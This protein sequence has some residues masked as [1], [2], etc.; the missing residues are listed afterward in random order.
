MPLY[1]GS[2]CPICGK[3][4]ADTDD[5]VV[6]PIC[7][8]PHHRECYR[9][10]GHCGNDDYHKDNRQWELPEELRQA[11]EP[12]QDA[13]TSECLNC[14]ARNPA[15]GCFCQ[16]CGCRLG[17]ERQGAV[18]PG[19]QGGGL[20]EDFMRHANLDYNQV[21]DQG[22]T[23]KDACDYV[24]QNS[25]PF[26]LKFRAI[27]ARGGMTFN[28]CAFFFGFFYCF[29]RKMYK[30]GAVLLAIFLILLIPSGYYATIAIQ[31][32]IN[33]GAALTLPIDFVVEGEGFKGLMMVSMI[34]R[35]VNMATMLFS[36]FFFNKLYY[37]SMLQKVKAVRDNPRISPGTQEY[38][39][40]VVAQGGVNRG[41]VLVLVALMVVV[42]MFT[43]FVASL[44]VVL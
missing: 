19:G 32:I 6:C 7:G 34:T 9:V 40:A 20:F 21:L 29:Y 15:G 44:F 28:W 4:F 30:L 24:G 1:T 18:P 33:S 17:G 25:I 5:I 26:V 38:C 14:G 39:S 43:G 13:D 27:A 2:N 12:Q 35:V 16:S 10:V 31:D 22:V 3:T 37:N 42:Y 8:S 36:G 41:V 23:V 11:Q